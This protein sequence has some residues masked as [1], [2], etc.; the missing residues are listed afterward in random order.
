MAGP[1]ESKPNPDLDAEKSYSAEIGG[2]IITRS[3]SFDVAVFSNW[4]N[5]LIEPA[6]N[7]GSTSEGQFKNITEARVAGTELTATYARAPFSLSANYLYT[8]SRDLQTDEPLPYR[9]DHNVT[10]SGK[11]YYFRDIASVNAAWRYK[12]KR[13]Y[14]LYPDSPSVPENILDIGHSLNF[15]RYYFNFKIN[16]LLQYHYSEAEKGIEDIRNFVF[17]VGLNI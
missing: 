5:D 17:S 7:E 15:G 12:S 2:N 16:N 14:S 11:L 13:L 8:S 6:V 1:V 3:M 4:Y 10:L 9:P